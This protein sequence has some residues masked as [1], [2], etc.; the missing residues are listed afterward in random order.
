MG[1][2]PAPLLVQGGS[3]ASSSG[4]PSG[5]GVRLP[6]P[7]RAGQMSGQPPLSDLSR[8][9]ACLRRPCWGLPTPLPGPPSPTSLESS[10]EIAV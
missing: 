9:P 4:P 8:S 1:S 5:G 3:L 6:R 2:V 7:P 10:Q